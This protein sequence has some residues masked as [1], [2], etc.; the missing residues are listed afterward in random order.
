MILLPLLE[1]D[2]DGRQQVVSTRRKAYYLSP[3][4]CDEFSPALSNGVKAYKHPH[5]FPLPVYISSTT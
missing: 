4:P 1:V 2:D 3:L 5:D